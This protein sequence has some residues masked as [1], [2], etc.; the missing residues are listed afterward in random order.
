[1]SLWPSLAQAAPAYEPSFACERNHQSIAIASDGSYRFTQDRIVRIQ[2]DLARWK[3]FL[4]KLQRD[5]RSQV[6]YR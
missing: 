6:V 2:R 3:A 4:P 5:L 1:M